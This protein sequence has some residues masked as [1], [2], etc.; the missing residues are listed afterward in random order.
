MVAM[1]LKNSDLQLLHELACNTAMKAGDIISAART[2]P[3]EV[4]YK[5]AGD[6][7]ASQVVTAIDRECDKLIRECLLPSCETYD[8]ALLSEEED[9]DQQ[10]LYKEYFWCVDPLDGTLAFTQGKPGYA[11]SIALVARDATPLIG[12]VYDPVTQTVSS[13][14]KGL[15]AFR[16]GGSWELSAPDSTQLTIPVDDGL[17]KRDDF[18][19]ILDALEQWVESS[20]L[21]RLTQVR[22]AGA[23]MSAIWVAENPHGCYFKLPKPNTGGGSIWDFAATSCIYQELGLHVSDFKGRSLALNRKESTY[24]N[25]SGVILTS[26]PALVPVIQNLEN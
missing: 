2:R 9:D 20:E 4:L 26:N 8:F 1:R 17:H 6:T 21:I 22:H 18:S 23:V 3:I 15:G 24:M 16:N 12:V 5:Q 13:A 25:L 11:V 10:R 14:V 19:A 7:L